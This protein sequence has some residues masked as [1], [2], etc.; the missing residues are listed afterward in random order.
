MMPCIGIRFRSFLERF[1][2]TGTFLA[3]MGRSLR[4]DKLVLLVDFEAHFPGRCPLFTGFADMERGV[5][6][7]VVV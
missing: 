6:P 3:T 5:M 4:F 7:L 2:R 1:L